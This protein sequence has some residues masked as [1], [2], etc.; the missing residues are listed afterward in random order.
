[1][2]LLVILVVYVWKSSLLM[3]SLHL[4]SPPGHQTV[5]HI[6]WIV[7]GSF[8]HKP[9]TI[10]KKMKFDTFL[11]FTFRLNYQGDKV[12]HDRYTS[13]QEPVYLQGRGLQQ[14]FIS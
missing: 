14:Y 5:H 2:T 7:A 1:M 8:Q 11:T 9:E 6:H 12:D 4:V 13:A 10:V 3:S